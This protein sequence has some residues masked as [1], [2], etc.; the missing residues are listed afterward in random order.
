M[1]PAKTIKYLR[2]LGHQLLYAEKSTGKTQMVKSLLPP[3]KPRP[4][5][6]FLALD[7]VFLSVSLS[8]PGSDVK[9]GVLALPAQLWLLSLIPLISHTK[10][11]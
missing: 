9:L 11:A 8:G 5:G 6:I 7:I 2:S 3:E 4:A 10:R 1:L